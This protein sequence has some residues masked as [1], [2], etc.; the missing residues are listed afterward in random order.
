MALGATK[1]SVIR[2]VVLPF[3]RGGFIGAVMLGLGRALGETIAV[4]I[5]ISPSFIITAHIFDAGSELDRG[6]HRPRI[7]PGRPVRRRSSP[8]RRLRA[9]RVHAAREL[10]RLL[11]R[12]PLAHRGERLMS[13]AT[14]RR[15]THRRSRQQ[16]R[17][18]RC[19]RAATGIAHA[20]RSRP[21]HRLGGLR[22][23]P[24]LVRLLPADPLLRRRRVRHGFDRRVPCRVL[25]RQPPGVR[26]DG[27]HLT[28][29]SARS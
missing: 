26:A 6:P 22:G 8:R 10:R 20:G 9:V 1:A 15:V 4:A 12:E 28:G 18:R 2:T 21:A 14:L 29:S 17:R 13:I 7:R 23:L 16:P 24:R 25:L 11:H 5:I 3:G 19:S 27:R